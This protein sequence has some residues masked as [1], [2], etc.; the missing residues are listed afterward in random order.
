MAGER[1]I[2]AAERQRLDTI[3]RDLV[4]FREAGMVAL[5]DYRLSIERALRNDDDLPITSTP[6]SKTRLWRRRVVATGSLGRPW[7]P[8][9]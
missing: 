9:R 5:P 7:V 1:M 8:D 4:V 2:L 3:R 6:S